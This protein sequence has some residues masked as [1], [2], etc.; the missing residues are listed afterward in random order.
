MGRKCFI[1]FKTE[2]ADYKKA[3][4]DMDIDM[5]DKSLDVAIDSDN[6]DHI[7]REIRNGYLKDST[8][9]LHL[10]G[11]HGAENVGDKEQRFI[12]RE[13]QA[14]L[15][16]GEGDTKN[17]ILGI[18]LPNAYSKVYG[19]T[20]QCHS[21]GRGHNAVNI[22]DTTTISEFSYNYYIPNEKCSH[23][24]E[25]RYC[26]LVKWDDFIVN[27]EYYIECAFEKRTADISSKTKVRP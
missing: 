10:I 8:V 23:N 13:L 25:D 1:S 15:F 20:Y 9:T 19:G 5:V 26:V 4:Q 24:E 3:I 12:K 11:L 18:V 14:S 21:C 6:E 7:M 22:N 27:P 17:G 16:H 2:D